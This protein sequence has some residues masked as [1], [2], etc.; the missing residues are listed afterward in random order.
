MF[1][2]IHWIGVAVTV[3][4]YSWLVLYTYKWS[5]KEKFT[6]TAKDGMKFLAAGVVFAGGLVLLASVAEYALR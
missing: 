4:A 1:G 5:R 3:I 6:G 2:D